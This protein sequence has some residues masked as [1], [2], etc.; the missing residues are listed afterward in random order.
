MN[1][2]KN[3]NNKN[4]FLKNSVLIIISLSI[5]GA[6]LILWLGYKEQNKS[7]KEIKFT[8]PSEKSNILLK[9]LIRRAGNVHS[10]IYNYQK[11]LYL[12]KLEHY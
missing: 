12:S 9:N 4:I 7:Y 2:L 5:I 10:P 1:D 11:M 8:L 6:Q 3:T